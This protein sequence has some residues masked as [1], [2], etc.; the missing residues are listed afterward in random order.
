M[1]RGRTRPSWHATQKSSLWHVAQNCESLPAIV[2][3][4]SIQSGVWAALWSQRGGVRRPLAKRV[5]IVPPTADS[6]V[7]AAPTFDPVDEVRTWQ[8][9][10]SLLA[11][12]R[13]AESVI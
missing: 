2:L 8:V 5:R 7:L 4:R 10:Q 13:A 3:W 12:P 9:R 11:S 6:C 1:L